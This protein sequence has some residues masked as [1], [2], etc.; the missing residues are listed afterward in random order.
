MLSYVSLATSIDRHTV[1]EQRDKSISFDMPD[2][3]MPH[4]DMPHND[5]MPHNVMLVFMTELS[6]RRMGS[7][8]LSPSAARTSR[9]D[10][11]RPIEVATSLWITKW[12]RAPD[13]D[14]V[15]VYQP[16]T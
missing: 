3:H 15:I 13:I 1:A 14:F 10:G 5:N 7:T 8:S 11:D 4:N 12:R 2:S 6:E 16:V 9:E